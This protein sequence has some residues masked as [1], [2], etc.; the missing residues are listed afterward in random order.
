MFFFKVSKEVVKAVCFQSMLH[1]KSYL[2][3]LERSKTMPVKIRSEAKAAHNYS[4]QTLNS[5][6]QALQKSRHILGLVALH[7]QVECLSRHWLLLPIVLFLA[8]GSPLY[9]F[10]GVPPLRHA[11]AGNA[12]R[13]RATGARA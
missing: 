13:I 6:E 1:E 11:S 8:T 5:T 10:V 3:Q 7:F 12:R 4:T 9:V 2:N